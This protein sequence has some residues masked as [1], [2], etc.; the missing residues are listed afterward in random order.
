ME[1]ACGMTDRTHSVAGHERCVAGSRGRIFSGG[2]GEWGGA[3]RPR[4]SG[5]GRTAA[6]AAG[7][8]NDCPGVR[9]GPTGQFLAFPGWVCRSF[10]AL[11]GQ[12]PL[13]AR[14]QPRTRGDITV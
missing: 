13:C 10:L 7:E 5:P 9:L 1:Y 8:L 4:A 12:A 6:S 2:L 14:R 3:K 11:V